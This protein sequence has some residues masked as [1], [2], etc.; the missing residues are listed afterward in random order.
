MLNQIIVYAQIISEVSKI[1]A[2]KLSKYLI[3]YTILLSKCSSYIRIYRL[4][5]QYNFKIDVQRLIYE[6]YVNCK[7]LKHQKSE[8]LTQIHSKG[9]S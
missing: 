1:Y 5:R 7:A 3:P 4:G 9:V 8:H 2:K 6:A